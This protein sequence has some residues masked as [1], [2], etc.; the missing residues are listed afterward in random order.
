MNK[1]YNKYGINHITTK[2]YHPACNGLAEI[3][4][5]SFNEEI[6][7]KQ[8]AGQT[9]KYKAL[10]NVLRSYR[11]TLH[12]STGSSPANMMLH[13]SI[14]TALDRVFGMKFVQEFATNPDNCFSKVG[15]EFLTGDWNKNVRKIVM[16]KTGRSS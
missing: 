6:M 13:H 7:K 3:F 10:R 11:W 5:R 1:F 9:D 16:T 15:S 12:A 4:V 8:Q 14:R 2:S